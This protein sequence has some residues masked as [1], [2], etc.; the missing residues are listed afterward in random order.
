MMSPGSNNQAHYINSSRTILEAYM[1]TDV[2]HANTGT[3]T[4]YFSEK[5]H[6]KRRIRFIR[7]NFLHYFKD[8]YICIFSVS[9]LL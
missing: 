8:N 9:I 7:L 6:Q 2:S 5:Q 4:D 3:A 1:K